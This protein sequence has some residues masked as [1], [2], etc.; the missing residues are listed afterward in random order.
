MS[1]ENSKLKA[2]I[3]S[4]TQKMDRYRQAE[5]RGYEQERRA[6]ELSM[7]VESMKYKMEFAVKEGQRMKNRIQ[8]LEET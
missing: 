6:S 4:L 1:D 7:T 3:N 8:E 2:E 5:A